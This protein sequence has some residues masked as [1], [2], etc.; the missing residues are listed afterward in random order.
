MGLGAYPD[1]ERE[2]TS[3][4]AKPR[5]TWKAVTQNYQMGLMT[6]SDTGY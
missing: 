5:T 3:G 2:G 1:S 4:A 6:T